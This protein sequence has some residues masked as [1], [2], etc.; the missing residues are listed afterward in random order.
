MEQKINADRA[1]L[2]YAGGTETKLESAIQSA[3]NQ[4]GEQLAKLQGLV[5]SLRDRLNPLLNDSQDVTGKEELPEPVVSKVRGQIYS[6]TNLVKS[7][8][9]DISLLLMQLEV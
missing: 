6:Q 1:Q 8:Q 2:G 3:I 5:L 4:H 7:I 9:S